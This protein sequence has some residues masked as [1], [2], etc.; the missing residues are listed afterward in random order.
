[1]LTPPAMPAPSW[2]ALALLAPAAC[3]ALCAA[4]G[5]RLRASAAWA[6][7]GAGGGAAAAEIASYHLVARKV[8]AAAAGALLWSSLAPRVSVRSGVSDV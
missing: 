6:A 3:A 5:A 2:L 1:M 7:W 4:P 8:G